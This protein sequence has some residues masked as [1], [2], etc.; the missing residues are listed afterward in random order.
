MPLRSP[1]FHL[2]IDDIERAHAGATSR[3]MRV[4]AILLNSPH[5]PLG[6]VLGKDLIQDVV[7]F[8]SRRDIHVILDEVYAESLLPGVEHYT[9]LDLE[10]PLVHVVYGF[11]KDF[12]LSGYK[13]GILHSE[14]QEVLAATQ[15]MAYFH[16]VS[17]LA[18]RVLAGVIRH[19]RLREFHATLRERLAASYR[20]ATE[21]LSALGIPF[22]AAQGGIVLWLDLSS[23]LP[24][25]CP[26]RVFL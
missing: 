6:W 9:G 5:N 18:Q 14:N 4:A 15:A 10:S 24:A 12:G 13:A 17:M 7:D 22:V 2:G 1:E 26:V 25:A 20:R 8:A 19:P 11:A 21:D 3:G 23:Y 16:P